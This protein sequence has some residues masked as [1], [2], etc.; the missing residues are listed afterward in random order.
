MNLC[1]LCKYEFVG[2]MNVAVLS[3]AIMSNINNVLSIS[4]LDSEM[5]RGEDFIQSSP[6]HLVRILFCLLYPLLIPVLAGRF[7][8][9]EINVFCCA[10]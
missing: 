7:L 2:Y 5:N 9:S 3:V 10:S 8:N 6:Y 4:A 1:T